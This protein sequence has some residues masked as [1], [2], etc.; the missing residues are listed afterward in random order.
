MTEDKVVPLRQPPPKEPLAPLRAVF[1][2]RRDGKPEQAVVT[3]TRPL[4]TS[5]FLMF[6]EV[7]ERSAIILD[8]S[9]P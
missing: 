3:F 5:E 6:A 7:C 8:E 9:K 2:S 4:T 1:L